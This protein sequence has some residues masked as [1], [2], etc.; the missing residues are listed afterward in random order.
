MPMSLFT[1]FC[2]SRHSSALQ[3]ASGDGVLR[4]LP[5]SSAFYLD[6][7]RAVS[8]RVRRFAFVLVFLVQKIRLNSI[9]ALCSGAGCCSLF[10]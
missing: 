7:R 10:H 9:A 4:G 2:A 1:H 5:V 3:L 8:S 6:V